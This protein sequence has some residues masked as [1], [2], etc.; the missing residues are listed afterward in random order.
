M[1]IPRRLIRSVVTVGAVAAL[2]LAPIAA[3]AQVD[4]ILR[5]HPHS[6]PPRTVVST[7]GSGLFWNGTCG[8][9]AWAVSFVDASG[10]MSRWPVVPTNTG[11]FRLKIRVP[12]GAA[13]GMGKINLIHVIYAIGECRWWVFA[14]RRFTVTAASVSLRG[15][16]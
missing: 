12:S 9:N 5:I 8:T 7:H 14:T 6:G 16:A 3:P 10:A 11:S 4:V 2:T 13:L 15:A 1:R